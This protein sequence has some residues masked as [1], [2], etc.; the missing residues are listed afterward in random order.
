MG[1]IDDLHD[2]EDQAQAD[3]HEAIH[4]SHENPV[5]NGLEKKRKTGKAHGVSPPEIR[6]KVSLF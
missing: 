1:E 6:E 5:D 4:P 3:G 2:P